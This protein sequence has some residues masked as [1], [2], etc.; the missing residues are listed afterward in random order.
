MLLT[1]TVVVRALRLINSTWKKAGKK[2]SQRDTTKNW[3]WSIDSW[4]FFLFLM[5]F[6]SIFQLFGNLSFLH[7]FMP[8][9]EILCA[10]SCKEFKHLQNAT[11]ILL[12]LAWK[13][14][15]RIGIKS[16]ADKKFCRTK[17]SSPSQTFVNFVRQ[18]FVR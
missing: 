4:I 13:N 9:I 15:N 3:Q 8:Q 17:L 7:Y 10:L 11:E 18:N 14:R 1:I 12:V 5:N 6:F 2:F 16:S